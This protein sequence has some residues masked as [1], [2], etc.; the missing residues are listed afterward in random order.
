MRHSAHRPGRVAVVGECV[1]IDQAEGDA[2]AFGGGGFSPVR[3]VG[4]PGVQRVGTIDEFHAPN[5]VHGLRT[6]RTIRSSTW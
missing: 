2:E 6:R 5:T 4:L 1:V 3:L